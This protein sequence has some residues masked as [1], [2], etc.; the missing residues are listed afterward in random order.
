MNKT[1]NETVVLGRLKDDPVRVA[2]DDRTKDYVKFFICRVNNDGTVDEHKIV[3]FGKQADLCEKYIHKND[4]CCIEGV[5]C[6]ETSSRQIIAKK[7][8][9]LSKK[10]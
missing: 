8:T 10:H 5:I 6:T 9:F 1:Y 2:H 3:S 4:L 7:I